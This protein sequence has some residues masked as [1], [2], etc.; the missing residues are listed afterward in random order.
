MNSLFT[1]AFQAMFKPGV[2]TFDLTH[3]YRAHGAKGHY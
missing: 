3:T 1:E 2:Y